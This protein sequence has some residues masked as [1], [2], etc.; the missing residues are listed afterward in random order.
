MKNFT[1]VILYSVLL[2][3]VSC[4]KNSPESES[5]ID[6]SNPTN[7]AICDTK[8]TKEVDVIYIYPTVV[9]TSETGTV[10]INDITMREGALTAYNIQGYAIGK[11]ANQFVPYYR[12][13]PFDEMAAHCTTNADIAEFMRNHQG[14]KDVYAAMDYYFKNLN[15]GRPFIITGHSQGSIIIKLLMEEYMKE[16]PAY[17]KR[18][19]AAYALGFGFGKKYYQKNTHL[20]YAKG[21]T[22]TGVIISWNLEAPGATQT[23]LLLTGDDICINPLSWKVDYEHAPA[24]LNPDKKHDAQISAERGSVIVNCDDSYL[25]NAIFGDKSYH[26]GDWTFFFDNL[27]INAQKRIEAFRK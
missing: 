17:L 5:K 11:L 21:E 25:S 10:D 24:S 19:V 13:C 7:W 16:H 27:T 9:M 26:K 2:L 22:D 23:N 8:P 15:N 18:M 6:Y 4:K 14:T 20:K 1:L 3:L 12:Q